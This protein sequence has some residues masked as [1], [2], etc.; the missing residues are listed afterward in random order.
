MHVEVNFQHAD[1]PE[2]TKLD[3]DPMKSFEIEMTHNCFGE[4]VDRCID[5]QDE[6]HMTCNKVAFY[7]INIIIKLALAQLFSVITQ[8]LMIYYNVL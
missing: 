3:D 2:M 4:F 5:C 8:Y 1:F 7:W 6:L